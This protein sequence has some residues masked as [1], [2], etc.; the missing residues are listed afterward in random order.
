MK[1]WLSRLI[2]PWIANVIFKIVPL[3]LNNFIHISHLNVGNMWIPCR[4]EVNGENL[5]AI[6]DNNG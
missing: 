1:K 2:D 3:V 6:T 5:Y 4:M